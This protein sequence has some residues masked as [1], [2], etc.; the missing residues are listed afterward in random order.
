LRTPEISSSTSTI[1]YMSADRRL[2]LFERPCGTASIGAK[3]LFYWSSPDMC[4]Y[5][6][7]L[8]PPTIL[9]YCSRF[10]SSSFVAINDMVSETEKMFQK[11]L[12]KRSFS[13]L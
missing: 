11:K 4:S 8:Y 12:K 7:L 13:S 5:I 9:K 6:N 3:V 1:A 10:D 2:L